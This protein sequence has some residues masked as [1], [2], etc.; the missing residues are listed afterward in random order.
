MLDGYKGKGI[1]LPMSAD[2]QGHPIGALHG[3]AKSDERKM[4][5]P[6]IAKSNVFV[7]KDLS[8]LTQSMIFLEFD[9]I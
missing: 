7:L 4:V 9:P 8:N 2:S 6:L 5:L 3:S 1:T